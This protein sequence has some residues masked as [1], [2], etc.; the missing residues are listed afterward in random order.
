[1]VLKVL[2][3]E[4]VSRVLLAVAVVEVQDPRATRVL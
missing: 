3:D 4:R 2:L 1:L